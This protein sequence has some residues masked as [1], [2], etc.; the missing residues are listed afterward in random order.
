[1][2]GQFC[3]WNWEVGFA[4]R[5]LTLK[6]NFFLPSPSSLWNDGNGMS[7]YVFLCGLHSRT[8]NLK[9]KKKLSSSQAFGTQPLFKILIWQTSHVRDF[10]QKSLLIKSLTI[11][12]RIFFLAVKSKSQRV[13]KTDTKYS[14]FGQKLGHS[15]ISPKNWLRDSQLIALYLSLVV[16]RVLS[17]MSAY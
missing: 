11:V 9:D 5:N 17:K 14:R 8:I 4:W 15:E 1:M 3:L 7:F 6:L 2:T 13:Y 10:G 12:N 16:M